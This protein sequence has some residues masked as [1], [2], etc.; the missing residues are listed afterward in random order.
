MT[1]GNA[2]DLSLSISKGSNHPKDPQTLV[3]WIRKVM[4]TEL[5]DPSTLAMDTTF[6]DPDIR[7]VRWTGSPLYEGIR[8]VYVR[9]ETLSRYNK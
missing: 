4:P 8:H 6:V 2:C 7:I 5:F 1:M 9:R 3:A